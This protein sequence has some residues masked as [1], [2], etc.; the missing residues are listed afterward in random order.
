MKNTIVDSISILLLK[1][2]Y[3][4]KSFTRVCFDILARYEEKILLIKIVENANT[5]S[6]EYV[7]EM[8]HIA[9][10]LGASPLIVAQKA[11]LNLED[12]VVYSRLG[13]NTLNVS[14]FDNALSNKLPF[15]H[16][17]HAGL[18]VTIRASKLKQIR[19][20]EGYSLQSFST[21]IGVSRKMVAVV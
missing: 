5:L 14:T 15:I 18:T 2:G 13:I 21:K 11:G 17:N 1:Y 8:R 4:V 7:N 19:E 6:K 3:T 12:N 16:S 10:Y 9:G 20:K